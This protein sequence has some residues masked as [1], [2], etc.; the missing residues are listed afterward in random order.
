MPKIVL[1]N[2]FSLSMISKTP[3]AVGIWEATTEQVKKLLQGGFESAVG[4]PATAS[5]LSKLLGMPVKAERK[6][7]TLDEDTILV[8]F[9]LLTRLPE[10]K[11]LSEEELKQLPHKWFIVTP[12]KLWLTPGPICNLAAASDNVAQAMREAKIDPL[13]DWA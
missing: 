7:V 10:G 2:A 8:V 12:V 6:M 3:T 13:L 9:Q 4:H 1:C 11:I 5:L